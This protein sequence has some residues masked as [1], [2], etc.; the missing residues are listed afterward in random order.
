MESSKVQE[1]YFEYLVN[2]YFY[3]F[4]SYLKMQ[5]Q[6]KAIELSNQVKEIYTGLDLR[7]FYEKE[8]SKHLSKMLDIC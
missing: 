2:A 8:T 7:N 6:L 1:Y 5:K 4:T 3:V